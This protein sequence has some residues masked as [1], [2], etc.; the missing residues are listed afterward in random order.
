MS[1][2]SEPIENRFAASSDLRLW[3]ETQVLRRT[4]ELLE[5]KIRERTAA[6]RLANEQ[7]EQE[8]V[9]RKKTADLL[10]RRVKFDEILTQIASKFINVTIDAIDR[11]INQALEVVGDFAQ[12]DRAYLYMLA[13]NG[14]ELKNSHGWYRENC[15]AGFQ[16]FQTLPANLFELWLPKLFQQE[17]IR[18]ENIVDSNWETSNE[19]KLLAL[20]GVRSALIIP[21]VYGNQIIGF[22][23]LDAISPTIQWADENMASLKIVATIFVNALMRK[24]TD[25]TLQTERHL[26]QNIMASMGQG[27][28]LADVDGSYTFVNPAFANMLS[29]TLQE[30]SG[31]TALD[32]AHQDDHPTLIHAQ[33]SQFR[34]ESTNYEY[35]LVRQ[36]GS[37]VYVLAQGVPHYDPEGKLIGSIT[38]ITDLTERRAAE[39]QIEANAAET[40]AIYQA[41]VQLLR[42]TNLKDLAEQIAA[43]ATDELGFDNCGVLLLQEPI[44]LSTDRLMLQSNKSDNYLTWLA[45]MGRYCDDKSSILPLSE[46]SLVTTA[47]RQGE[48]VYSPD[49]ANDPHYLP[50]STY[51]QSELVIPLRAYN[52]IIGAMDLQSPHKN[53]FDERTQRIIRVFAKHAGMALETM[54]LYGKL[55]EHTTELEAQITGRNQVEQALRKS[56][57]RYKHLVENVSDMLYRTDANGFCTYANPVT[58]RILGFSSEDEL[59]GQHFTKFI[60]RNFRAELLRIY[61]A[62]KREKIPN[63]Y[64]EFLALDKD[65]NELW[66]GQNVQ[67]LM[68]NDQVIGYQALARNITKRREAEDKLQNRSNELNETNAK[69]AKALRAKDEF[70]AN[71][72]HELRTPLN[73]I[74]GKSEILHEGI[75]GPLNEK[76]AASIRVIEESGRHLLELINDILDL[77]KIESGKIDLDIQT[78]SIRGLCENSLQFVRQLAHKKQ[79]KLQAN[80]SPTLKT[81]RA[82]ERRLKQIL[83]NLLSNAVKFTPNEGEVGLNISEDAEREVI[84]FQVWDSGIGISPEDMKR[85][86]QPFV[87]L[88]SSLARSHEGT[89]LGLSLV[90]QLTEMH[91]GSVSLES[92][93]GVGSCFTVTLPENP[94]TNFETVQLQAKTDQLKYGRLLTGRLPTV[95]GKGPR[96]LLVEDNETNIEMISEYLPV[97]GYRLL[98]ARSGTA[99]MTQA[100]EEKPDLILMDIQIPEMDGLTAVRQLRQDEQ[101]KHVPIIALTALAMQG[102]REQCLEAGANEYLS[103]PVQLRQLVFLI[104]QLLAEGNNFSKECGS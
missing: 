4:N 37:M 6:L 65:K 51:T 52:L 19:K 26:A 96:I 30:V 69:L 15:L 77:A 2:N 9:E 55:Q 61:E 91:G 24:K 90:Y 36:D 71:M 27:L 75:Q 102:D 13:E 82:D 87:Q 56:E 99:A 16:D 88:D 64:N 57:Q 10:R 78:V 76:Q 8:I 63:V 81:C 1:T 59:I 74:L 44:R 28:T 70:L 85:L 101:F 41:V 3:Q 35:R 79:I 93:A 22:L 72:S 89:G 54:R 83:I 58:V 48:I 43:I 80:I 23:G 100:Y 45:R 18:L 29:T 84:Q 104:D 25:Q 50:E 97:W 86:F 7:L 68:K 62:Q 42:P 38:T 95:P 40:R 32:F 11:N 73:A 94:Q 103:K 53:G 49:V 39:D 31:K 12:F 66:L 67:L 47:V 17:I 92:Q 14:R 20:Q 5:K 98:V 33:M 21:L 34:G 46:N 60:H